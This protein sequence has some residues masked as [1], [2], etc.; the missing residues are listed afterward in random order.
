M[1]PLTGLLLAGLGVALALF[2]HRLLQ[3][4]RAANLT[5]W[6]SGWLNLLDG[7]NR[8]F[9][10]RFHRMN[11]VVLPLPASGPAI[12]VANHVSG[13][14]PLLLIAASRR[15]LRFLV[16]REQYRRPALGW[17]LRA[18]GCI[19]VDREERPQ[20]A[21]RQGM[22]SLRQGKVI[23]LFPEGRIRVPGD[24]P[25]QLKPGAAL[26]AKRSGAPLI[27]VRIAGVRGV[28]RILGAVLLRSRVDLSLRRSIGSEGLTVSQIAEQLTRTFA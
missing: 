11:D 16:A 26:M 7:A 3:V 13:L 23:A 21:L 24:G 1:E 17:L 4:L 22:K 9:C 6:G 20:E 28:G 15:P 14:D 10:L 2:V 12:V 8:L 5:D 27:P 25:A 18:V 19:P